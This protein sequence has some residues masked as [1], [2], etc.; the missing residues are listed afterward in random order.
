[1]ID[2]LQ[3]RRSYPDSNTYQVEGH[4]VTAEQLAVRSFNFGQFWRTPDMAEVTY[5]VA[6]PLQYFIDTLAAEWADFTADARRFPDP[7]DPFE[8]ALRQR[9]W[10][11][12]AAVVAD[13]EMA[14]L[15][16]AWWG[17]ELLLNWFGDG[18][19]KGQPGFVLNTIDRV[20]LAD[21]LPTLTGRARN[22][23]LSVAYQDI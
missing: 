10:P 17:H 18:E 14:Q 8:N 21:G 12:P 13:A 23:G 1:M 19:P 3:L 5:T 20:A 9:H 6:L 16:L 4:P 7:S 15:A 22:A 2:P 11:T